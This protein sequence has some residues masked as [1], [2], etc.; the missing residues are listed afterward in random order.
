MRISLA[1]L[2]ASLPP[3]IQVRLS[4]VPAC[5]EWS[6]ERRAEALSGNGGISSQTVRKR[7]S[8]G[9]VARARYSQARCCSS[10]S[11]V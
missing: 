11:R 3:T 9:R 8:V 7:S 4:L 6:L 2:L 10:E 1:S 5:F